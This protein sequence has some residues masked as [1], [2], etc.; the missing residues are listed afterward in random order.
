MDSDNEQ[1]DAQES[2]PSKRRRIDETETTTDQD[3]DTVDDDF[4][5]NPLESPVP[6]SEHQQPIVMFTG[7]SKIEAQKLKSIVS[8]L[9]GTVEDQDF[10]IC[11]HLVCRSMNRTM[12]F[13]CAINTPIHHF[14]SSEWLYKSKKQGKFV[15]EQLYQLQDETFEKYYNFSLQKSLEISKGNLEGVFHGH[16]FLLT[17]CRQT[18]DTSDSQ[19][20]RKSVTNPSSHYFNK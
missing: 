19:W 6:N 10:S 7:F 15:S 12:K 9:G 20:A 2:S 8:E 17:G 1:E 4:D 14:M 5:D 13:L 18:N 16:L 3:I 11:T